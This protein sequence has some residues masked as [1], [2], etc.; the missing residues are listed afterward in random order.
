MSLGKLK[1]ITSESF[2]TLL[3]A[4]NPFLYIPDFFLYTYPYFFLLNLVAFV[5]CITRNKRLL[6][7]TTT[8]VRKNSRYTVLALVVI[9]VL[10]VSNC[11]VSMEP[12]NNLVPTTIEEVYQA[13]YFATEHHL[14]IL[15][16]SLGFSSMLFFVKLVLPS[17]DDVLLCSL[18]GTV[19]SAATIVM[20]FLTVKRLTGSQL[21][22]LL[23]TVLFASI[24]RVVQYSS[25]IVG[26]SLIGSFLIVVLVYLYITDH[27]SGNFFVI[28]FCTTLLIF[29]RIENIVFLAVFAIWFL[30]NL[31]EAKKSIIAGSLLGYVF[32]IPHTAALYNVIPFTKPPFTKP[33]TFFLGLQ[34]I[35]ERF[36]SIYANCKQT[37]GSVFLIL[38]ALGIIYLVLTRRWTPVLVCFS[39]VA[40][41][42]CW[43]LHNFVPYY[44]FLSLVPLMVVFIIMGLHS[45][46]RASGN[47][48]WRGSLLLIF[49]L[50]T[51]FGIEHHFFVRFEKDPAYI[52]P[53]II[54]AHE[55]S[56]K[57]LILYGYDDVL[58][59]YK[60]FYQ[61][62]VS[63]SDLNGNVD[64]FDFVIHLAEG[65]SDKQMVET[66]LNANLTFHEDLGYIVHIYRISHSK[67][68]MS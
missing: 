10:H 30:L 38:I 25:S 53:N 17:I 58:Y 27:K 18:V 28:L 60:R 40:A 68:S 42:G 39:L 9:V 67:T 5:F 26:T 2:A 66:Q 36:L 33:T 24:S 37:F 34:G 14:W 6:K 49:V 32:F 54:A 15:L 50:L 11:L 3:R 63:Y 43:Q 29:V 64:N 21:L 59:S 19:I 35:P 23:G 61:N 57:R 44:Y 22:S 51:V 16:R 4:I 13:H 47:R 8:L 62:S 55:L 12:L 7:E 41:Y 56:G 20:I 45:L 65:S 1:M 48:M 52:V 46:W 31:R